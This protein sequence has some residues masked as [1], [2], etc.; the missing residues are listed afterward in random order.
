MNKRNLTMLIALALAAGGG[1]AAAQE[2]DRDRDMNYP[3]AAATDP[4]AQPQ[5]MDPLAHD[6][7]REQI[8][9]DEWA[10]TDRQAGVSDDE[11]D[12]VPPR[13]GVQQEPRDLVHDDRTV[14]DLDRDID[15]DVDR[16][17]DG[18]V[19]A[20]HGS[21]HRDDL[22]D[23]DAHGQPI[24]GDDDFRPAQGQTAR[25][26]GDEPAPVVQPAEGTP[27][28]AT[29][30]TTGF[31]EGATAQQAQQ[32]FQR[33]DNDRSGG[34]GREELP[35]D[36][37][38]AQRFNDYDINN[39]SLISANEYQSFFAAERWLQDDAQREERVAARDD[40]PVDR[41]DS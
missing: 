32:Q 28:A 23:V 21:V 19:I 25:T 20:E 16:R 26:A 12:H 33:L 14:A 9:D 15:A 27:F 1:T 24:A 3:P 18:D 13:A 7:D 30:G 17:I 40:T 5:A 36:S 39:D 6:A 37:E 41:D 2:R 29:A 4:S 35:S 31:S 8:D 10:A 34:L 22:G 11:F 38:L